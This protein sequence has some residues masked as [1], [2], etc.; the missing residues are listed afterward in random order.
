MDIEPYRYANE[1]DFVSLSN[2]QESGWLDGAILE[3]L[4]WIL[5]GKLMIV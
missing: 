3:F 2:G 4:R 1:D 5:P